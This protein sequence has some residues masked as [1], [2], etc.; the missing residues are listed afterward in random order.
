MQFTYLKKHGT[1]AELID[2]GLGVLEKWIDQQI[3]RDATTAGVGDIYAILGRLS[4]IEKIDL[5]IPEGVDQLEN[6]YWSRYIWQEIL[7]LIE[8]RPKMDSPYAHAILKAWLKKEGWYDPMYT[9]DT[10]PEPLHAELQLRTALDGSLVYL[11]GWF[12]GLAEL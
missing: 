6:K 1:P 4:L 3:Q 5:S 11:Q 7:D 8:L 9:I 12:E 10:A 2:T